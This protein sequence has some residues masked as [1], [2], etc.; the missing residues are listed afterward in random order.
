MAIYYDEG[1]YHSRS[2]IRVQ[3]RILRIPQGFRCANVLLSLPRVIPQERWPKMPN[4]TWASHGSQEIK[5]D[6]D[7]RR[8]TCK[9]GVGHFLRDVRAAAGTCLY[10]QCR[11]PKDLPKVPRIP[12]NPG[13]LDKVSWVPVDPSQWILVGRRCLTTTARVT[14]E[15]T[16]KRSNLH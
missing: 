6:S 8:N 10:I 15:R 9:C 7:P 14:I 11:G 1:V 13:A 5:A 4:P 16:S 12:I 3:E 2:T